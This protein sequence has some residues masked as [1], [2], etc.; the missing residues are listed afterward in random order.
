MGKIEE[1]KS[2][3]EVEI[4]ETIAQGTKRRQKQETW[5]R[6]LFMHL[7]LLPV[8]MTGARSNSTLK[9]MLN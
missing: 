5:T 4:G 3:D 6:V 9:S 8:T 1:E 2:R 7:C